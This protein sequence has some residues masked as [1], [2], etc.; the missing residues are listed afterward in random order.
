LDDQCCLECL[1]R[2][3][4]YN[5]SKSEKNKT[6]IRNELYVLMMD[7]MLKWVKSILKKWNKYE[8]KEEILSLAKSHSLEWNEYGNQFELT[9][10]QLID[11]CQA[12]HQSRTDNQQAEINNLRNEVKILFDGNTE[13]FNHAKE[14]TATNAE[15]IEQVM[16]I[17]EALLQATFSLEVNKE[18][19]MANKCRDVLAITKGE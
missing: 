19:K 18:F 15:L 14:L 2:I 17:R 13:M 3:K 6:R 5:K 7:D 9:E 4:K 16:V 12:A 1:I 8:T 10:E 11:F